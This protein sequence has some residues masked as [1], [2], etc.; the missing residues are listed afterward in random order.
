M[1]HIK[2]KTTKLEEILLYFI[3][4]AGVYPFN[5]KGLPPCATF[6]EKVRAENIEGVSI[7]ENEEELLELLANTLL[8][9]QD[10]GIITIA[11]GDYIIPF[12]DFDATKISFKDMQKIAMITSVLTRS[13]WAFFAGI[14]WV[15]RESEVYEE[16]KQ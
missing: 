8:S 3:C 1:E 13:D 4:R 9:M 10:K 12:R 5:D 11:E 14:A 15:T 2:P 16:R 6:L 7:P